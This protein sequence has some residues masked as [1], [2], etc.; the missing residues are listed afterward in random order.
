[1]TP[2]EQQLIDGSMHLYPTEFSVTAQVVLAD[3]IDGCHEYKNPE[4]I[5]GKIVIVSEG[6]KIFEKPL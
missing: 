1:M 5:K 4:Q 6:T 2:N 3:P